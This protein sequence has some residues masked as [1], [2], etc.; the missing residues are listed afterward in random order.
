YRLTRPS[1]GRS[2]KGRHRRGKRLVV[3]DVPDWLCRKGGLPGVSRN[4]Q[5]LSISAR[6]WDN[7]SP[8]DRQNEVRSVK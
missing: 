5:R 2:G 4:S 8:N 6:H 1:T 3:I 7:Q